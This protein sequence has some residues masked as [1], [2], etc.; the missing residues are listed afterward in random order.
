[1]AGRAGRRGIDAEGKCVI[2]LDA[3]DG[4]EDVIRV[5]DGS[6]EPIE[7]QF[8]LGYGSVAL[9]LA[10]GMETTALRRRIEASFGQYQNLRRIREVETEVRRLESALAEA[11]G[12]AAP[13]GDFPRIGRYRRARQ[14]AEARRRA[15]GRGAGARQR[16]IVEA[17]PGRLALVRRKGAP[18][19][20]VI[21]GIHSIR[22][23]RVLVDA[24]LPH[25]AVVRLKAGALKQIFWST[26]SVAIPRDGGR[27]PRRL[28]HLARQLEGLDVREMIERDRRESPEAALSAIECHRCPWGSTTRCDQAWRDVERLTERL[29]QRRQALDALRNTYWQEFLRVVE[30]LEQFGAVRDRTLESKGRLIAGLRHD[31]ELLVAEIVARGL[32]GDLTLAEA[33]AV[34]SALSEESRSGEPMI[35]RGFLRSRPKL[36]RRLEQLIQVAEAVGEAQRQRHLPMPIAVHPGFMPSVFR[37]ASGDDDWASIVQDSFGGHEGDLI[38]A[39]RRLID[40]L[41]QLGESAEVPTPTARLLLEAARVIDR[42]IVLESALI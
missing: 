4:L 6:P 31:N 8:K 38:R 27:D 5:V 21:L 11:Q 18:S 16:G 22:G 3:R 12:F 23:H 2:A 13:C 35:A 7:S 34:C 40:L 14:E 10:T 19:L 26:P 33:A 17:E 15:S 39:M 9:L 29:A 42:G 1:M 30:V 32:L 24:L 28:R 41:R 25:G 36:R 37:W 20:A